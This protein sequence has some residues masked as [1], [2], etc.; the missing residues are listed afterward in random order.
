M[1]P[2]AQQERIQ[3]MCKTL[4]LDRV[5]I[6]YTLLAATGRGMATS[7]NLGGNFPTVGRFWRIGPSWGD[8]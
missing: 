4:K 1:S 3:A 8:G 7:S 6:D 5:A 2:A